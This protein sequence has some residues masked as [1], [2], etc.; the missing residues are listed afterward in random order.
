MRFHP[1]KMGKMVPLHFQD[2]FKKR[3]VWGIYCRFILWNSICKGIRFSSLLT[4]FCV[5]LHTAFVYFSLSTA[6][7]QNRPGGPHLNTCSLPIANPVFKYTSRL[8]LQPYE[9]QKC[10]SYPQ[11]SFQLFI[12]RTR[13]QEVSI[14]QANN[15]INSNK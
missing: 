2:G 11:R 1:Q 4:I 10:F 15:I 14:T 3:S 5:I 8:S 9:K 12:L 13:K 6:D 7:Q